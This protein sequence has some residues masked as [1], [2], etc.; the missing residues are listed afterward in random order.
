MVPLRAATKELSIRNA[1]ESCQF[2]DSYLATRNRRSH[3]TER[4]S[5]GR[6]ITAD[7]TRQ[8]IEQGA[9]TLQ[10]SVLRAQ[11]GCLR[12]MKR[13]VAQG[14]EGP[15]REMLRWPSLVRSRRSRSVSVG[16]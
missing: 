2:D 4:P 13:T 10:A 16:T 15:F 9:S 6:G 1:A 5:V 8:A 14:N 3:R 12:R 7:V 11:G